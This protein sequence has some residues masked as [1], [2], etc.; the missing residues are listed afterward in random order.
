MVSFT[1]P[2]R[3]VPKQ[4]PRVGRNGNMYTPNKSREYEKTVGWAAKQVFKNPISGPVSLQVRLHLT[5]TSGDLDNYIKTIQDGLNKIAW[6]DDRQVIQ[7]KASLNVR[8]GI[9]ERAEVVIQKLNG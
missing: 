7:L 8:P 3:P 9:R 2:G 6:L 5:S 1:I 4:R